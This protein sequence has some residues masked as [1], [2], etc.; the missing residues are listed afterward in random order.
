MTKS[1]K[2][3]A[4]RSRIA[5]L[6]FETLV[7][8][9]G[10]AQEPSEAKRHARLSRLKQFLKIFLSSTMS[11]YARILPLHRPASTSGESNLTQGRIAAAGGRFNSIC[12]LASM[13]HSVKAHW[14]HLVNTIELVLPSAPSPQT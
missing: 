13:C 8:K 3:P 2:I 7:F 14:R 9:N 5:V 4:H 1:L 10:S 11:E 12:R 6:P